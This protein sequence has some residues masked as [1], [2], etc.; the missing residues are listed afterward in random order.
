MLIGSYNVCVC[1]VFGFDDENV[2]G[3]DDE[4]DS[5]DDGPKLSHNTIT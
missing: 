1:N 4:N 3:F 5:D 2:R